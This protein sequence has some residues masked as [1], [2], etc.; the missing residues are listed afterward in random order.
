[1]IKVSPTEWPL[2]P[3]YAQSVF[4][5]SVRFRDPSTGYCAL[6]R[7]NNSQLPQSRAGRVTGDLPL[8]QTE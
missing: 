3:R 2:R 4:S 7:V 8:R 6:A 1:M 5:L